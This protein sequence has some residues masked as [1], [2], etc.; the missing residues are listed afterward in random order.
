MLSER[1]GTRERERETEKGR[2]SAEGETRVTKPRLVRGE[3]RR[4]EERRGEERR[5]EEK[6]GEKSRARWT[7]SLY[8]RAFIFHLASSHPPFSISSPHFHSGSVFLYSSLT[9]FVFLFISYSLALACF[10]ACP[11]L[12]FAASSLFSALFAFPPPSVT[13][14][15]PLRLSVIISAFASG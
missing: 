1:N 3:A 10:A 15:E 9:F 5:R 7:S 13:P 12:S 2:C 4:G 8:E 14:L 11:R 6:R